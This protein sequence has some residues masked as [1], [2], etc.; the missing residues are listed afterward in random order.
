MMHVMKLVPRIAIDFGSTSIRAIAE[1]QSLD[2]LFSDR[3]LLVRNVNSDDVVVMGEAA[4]DHIL[5]P[6]E[7][8][9]NPIQHG[10]MVD[11]KGAVSILEHAIRQV[12]SW[13]HVFKPQVVMP[14]SLELSSAVSQALGEAVQEA[15]GGKIYMTPIPALAALGA[16]INP[17]ESTGNFIIDIGGGSTE[18]AIISRGS[19]VS[20]LSAQIGGNDLIDSLITYLEN[21]H[22]VDV[23]RRAAADIIESAGSALNRDNDGIYD[24]YANE[25]KTGEAKVLSI[26]GNQIA[27]IISKPLQRIVSV[28]SSLIRRTPT[29]LLSDIAEN[30]ITVTGGLGRLYHIDT[31][32]KRELALPVHIIE[33][34]ENAVITGGK[35]AL[36]FIPVYERSVPRL[37]T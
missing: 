17:R 19:V 10:V 29:T 23:S 11:Y 27:D 12:S 16:K 3:S 7:E 28:A 21:T 35:E 1:G 36:K 18:A 4:E 34:P 13:W 32:L 22:A 30:G 25:I 14:E 33:N 37:N 2:R 20:G 5:S 6:G 31:F 9:I 15:G 24:F 8:L 26:S